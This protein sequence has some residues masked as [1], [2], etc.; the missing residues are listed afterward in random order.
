[1][2]PRSRKRC[3]EGK[4]DAW[5]G[6]RPSPLCGTVLR[7]RR[8][9]PARF[10][11]GRAVVAWEPEASALVDL[12]VVVFGDL[13][14]DADLLDEHVSVAAADD[15]AGAG[16]DGDLLVAGDGEEKARIVPY[17]LVSL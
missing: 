7:R 4:C 2:L 1:M 12:P 3:A 6:G 17:F 11:G 5:G 10:N 13:T 8:L 9:G 15:D 14:G 16:I